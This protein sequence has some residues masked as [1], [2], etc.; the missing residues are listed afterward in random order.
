[1][2]DLQTP[3]SGFIFDMDGVIVHNNDW[4]MKS[5]LAYAG[6]LGIHLPPEDFPERVYGKTNEEILLRFFPDA[7]ADWLLARSLE[8]EELYRR[9]YAPHFRL[10]DGLTSFLDFLSNLGIPLAVASNAPMVNIDFALDNG[11]I[12]H[13]FSHILSAGMVSRPKPAPDLYELAARRLGF[14]PGNCFVL[15]DSPSGLGAAV[16]AGCRPLAITSTFSEEELRK[17]T[18]VVVGSFDQLSAWLSLE[19]GTGKSSPS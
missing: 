8:K 16:A 19:I 13:Y 10:A 11:Q 12:R 4:H 3:S 15:E 2:A 1:M 18:P 17:F 9:M 14:P 7:G 6:Q 5:W